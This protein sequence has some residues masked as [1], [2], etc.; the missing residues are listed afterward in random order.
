MIRAWSRTYAQGIDFE[1][2]DLPGV[3]ATFSGVRCIDEVYQD[4]L[5]LLLAVDPTAPKGDRLVGY[6]RVESTVNQTA[7]TTFLA[8]LKDAGINPDQAIIDGAAIFP[9][10]LA[11]VWPKAA[12]QLCLVHETRRVTAAVVDVV[13][14]ARKEIPTPPS[15]ARLQLGGRKQKVA[16]LAEAT[17]DATERWRWRMA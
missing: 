4:Q 14:A 10:G 8:H 11:P 12:H 13:N 6:Q 2:D 3:V 1:R 16:P 15:R 7:M 5:A 17:D 9:P